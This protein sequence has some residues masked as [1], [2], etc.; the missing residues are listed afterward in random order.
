M[1]V[2]NYILVAGL[3]I[4]N[5]HRLQVVHSSTSANENCVRWRIASKNVIDY[6]KLVRMLLGWTGGVKLDLLAYRMCLWRRLVPKHNFE[7]LH[8]S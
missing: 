5:T 8:L 7:L 3:S 4:A 6:F 1:Q 2:V